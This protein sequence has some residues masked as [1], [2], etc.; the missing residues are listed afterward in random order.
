MSLARF[1]L[2]LAD[3]S[4]CLNNSFQ[5]GSRRYDPQAILHETHSSLWEGSHMCHDMPPKMRVSIPIFELMQSPV[6]IM[7]SETDAS[8]A[9]RMIFHGFGVSRQAG[10]TH[11]LQPAQR[12]LHDPA[13]AH[14]PRFA[15]GHTNSQSRN[16]Y[17]RCPTVSPGLPVIRES[18]R[19]V[20]TFRTG[21]RE[22]G[23]HNGRE[24]DNDMMTFST[25]AKSKSN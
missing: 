11:A 7:R 16:Q 6:S 12:H 3:Y 9:R 4:L 19:P 24:F 22:L 21:V 14:R 25:G 13:L 20:I 15:F 5:V 18:F 1:Q 17:A 23:P 8:A 2:S 10:F